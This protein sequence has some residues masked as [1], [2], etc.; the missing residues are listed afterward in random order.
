MN[1]LRCRG[2]PVEVALAGA[3]V[4]YLLS[5]VVMR[6][7]LSPEAAATLMR[8]PAIV[9][10]FLSVVAAYTVLWFCVAPRIDKSAILDAENRETAMAR[11]IA[12]HN[13][14]RESLAVASPWWQHFLAAGGGLIFG[15]LLAFGLTWLLA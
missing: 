11:L 10:A 1:R 3:V 14:A 8:F 9:I 15:L 4:A 13:A 12:A 2:T 7:F 6:D 5:A